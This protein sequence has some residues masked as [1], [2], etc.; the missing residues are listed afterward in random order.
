MLTTRTCVSRPY[1]HACMGFPALRGET[2]EWV[3]RS[4]WVKGPVQ[5]KSMLLSKNVSPQMYQFASSHFHIFSSGKPKLICL[6]YGRGHLEKE[7]AS[8]FKK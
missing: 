5:S 6:W 3:S 8:L 2:H 4:K 1:Y 7:K